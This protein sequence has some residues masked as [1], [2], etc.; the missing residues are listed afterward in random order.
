MSDLLIFILGGFLG[1]HLGK[2]ILAWRLKDIL[3]KEAL[4]EGID[5]SM[6]ED[7]EFNTPTVNQL[8]IERVNNVLYLYD[9]DA[10]SFVCQGSTIEE[11]AKLANQYKNIKYA[12]VMDEH[13]NDIVAFVD[14][15][16]ENNLVVKSHE[17]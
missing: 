15:R 4:K 11:L 12:S 5:I 2:M 9:K 10:G 14:G 13:T 1:Y 16:V 7:E 6:L 8:F 3:I 17:S